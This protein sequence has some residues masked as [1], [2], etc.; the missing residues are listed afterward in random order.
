[1]TPPDLSLGATGT[2]LTADGLRLHYAIHA[3]SD[4]PAERTFVVPLACWTLPDL[5]SA[6][7][8]LRVAGYDPRGRGR[9]DPV[10]AH[11]R[12]GIDADVDDLEFLRAA[13]GL[14]QMAILGWSYFGGVAARYAFAHPDRVTAIVLIGPLPLRRIPHFGQAAQAVAER[15]DAE[16]MAVLGRDARKG[17]HTADPESFCRGWNRALAPAY[18][19]SPTAL[20]R[21]RANPCACP[22]EHP[23]A[24]NTLLGRIWQGMGDWD[25]R[26]ELRR[27]SVPMLVL[28]GE[29]DFLP[30]A[31][32]EEW[33]A[34]PHAD[35]VV[36]P[37][38]GHLAWLD[39]PDA[40]ADAIRSFLDRS[41]GG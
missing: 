11:T 17:A 35:L 41:S 6:L 15:I 25:W 32:A 1:M 3:T 19:T 30:A 2:V 23:A 37:D 29:K 34:L 10:G 28:Q 38:A 21:M 40:V 20:A 26:K 12:L 5:A 8:P 16:A 39:R 7:P 18:T 22:N 24:V 13:L 36:V 4:W 33:G 31:A 9:S 27:L 14:E